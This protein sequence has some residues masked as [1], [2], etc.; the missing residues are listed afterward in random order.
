MITKDTSQS[1]FVKQAMILV[2]AGFICRSL[3]FILRIPLTNKL[4]D[5]GMAI[6]GGSHLTFSIFIVISM[7]LP[8][9]IS[10]L[11]SESMAVER[12]DE[13]HRIFKTALILALAIGLG[14]SLIMWGGA[15]FLAG[16]IN[17][18]NAYY[19]ILALSP[20]V[21]IVSVMAVFRGY[22]QGAEK[23]A[24][25]AVSQVVEQVFNLIFSVLL[26]F[27]FMKITLSE[28][29]PF[30][31]DTLA[32]GSAGGH[33]GTTM[34]AL[35][36]LIVIAM[37]YLAVRP[38][39]LR[40]VA[41]A[42]AKGTVTVKPRKR[43]DLRTRDIV[44][45][46]LRTTVPFICVTAIFTLSSLIDSRIITGRLMASG[47]IESE[48]LSMFG[49]YINKFVGLTNLPITIS[50]ALAVAMIP[51]LAGSR[52][53]DDLSAV[54]TKIGMA[55]KISMI[56]SFP[57]AI[58]IAVLAD[59]I[60]HFIFPSAPNG[61]G[62]LL[63][64]APAIIFIALTQVSAGALQGAGYLKIPVFAALT[65]TLLKIPLNYLLCAIPAINIY[66]AVI[67]TTVCYLVAC[68]INLYMTV[69]LTQA[70]IRWD[71]AFIRPLIS[72][73]GMGLTAYTAYH[74]FM[75]V[76]PSNAL[77]TIFAILIGLV[78]Y[79]YFMLLLDGFNERDISILPRGAEI[80]YVLKVRGWIR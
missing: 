18:P 33:L 49:M 80:A 16:F 66:G 67:S 71:E 14:G 25:T 69:R 50:T 31:G 56:I 47:F 48:Y 15:P 28:D 21:T 51:S 63:V 12:H 53:A 10:K 60:L 79:L 6:Y 3:G 32:L 55:I 74:V 19:T 7:G 57:A 20:A 54:R 8:L 24:A 35:M 62:L 23:M 34:G 65:G 5:E 36:G 17:I 40:V 13:A 30:F 70:R 44:G 59:P 78:S 61:A 37:L 76:V 9:S 42:A 64:G 46:L 68:A 38:T 41:R 27:A 11:T 4:G 52:A 72:A 45:L 29:N 26:M 77:G 75:V 73:V 22:F 39:I 1:G 43:R 2:V 58:G